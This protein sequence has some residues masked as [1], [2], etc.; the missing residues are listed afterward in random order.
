MSENELTPCKFCGG[1]AL[2]HGRF[3]GKKFYVG[4]SNCLVRTPYYPIKSYVIALWNSKYKQ[5]VYPCSCGNENLYITC[6]ICKE[7][8]TIDEHNSRCRFKLNG[9]MEKG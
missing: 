8:L 6:E 5:E 2:L 9:N 3:K 1:K 7:K 4:C